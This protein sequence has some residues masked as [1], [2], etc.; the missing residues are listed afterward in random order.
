MVSTID[1]LAITTVGNGYSKPFYLGSNVLIF[2]DFIG[3]SN[4]VGVDY[5]VNLP[6]LSSGY[7]APLSLPDTLDSYMTAPTCLN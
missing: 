1:V 2:L 5:G 4:D 6:L 3:C 7:V